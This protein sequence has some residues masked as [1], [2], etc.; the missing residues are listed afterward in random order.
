VRAREHVGNLGGSQIADVRAWRNTDAVVVR[1]QQLR[2]QVADDSRFFRTSRTHLDE[3]AHLIADS[4]VAARAPTAV[5]DRI[6]VECGLPVLPEPFL[7]ETGVKVIPRQHFGVCALA[8]A[9]AVSA[10]FI[11]R[12]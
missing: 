12:S 1:Q 8:L 9:S 11:Q 3:G 2:D 7:V 10:A 4:A 5:L 6:G